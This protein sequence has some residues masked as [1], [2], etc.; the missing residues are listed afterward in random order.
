VIWHCRGRLLDLSQHGVIMGIL[1]VTPDS[2]SDGGKFLSV[3][4]ACEHGLQM[5]SDGAD[6]LDIGGE[7]TRP[8][9]QPV[10]EAEELARVIPV[11]SALREKT[12]LPLSIDTTK[13]AVAEAALEAGA[14]IIN[15]V[16]GLRADKKMAEVVAR[17]QAGLVLMHMQGTPLTMQ[18]A[19]R[20]GNVVRE[21]GDFFRQSIARAIACGVNPMSI[22]LDPGVGF[23]KSPQHNAALLR[24]IGSF[25]QLGHPITVGV[26]RKSFLGWL[27]GSEQVSDRFWP[28]VAL[29]SFCR[30]R[31]GRIFRVHEPKPHCEA[32]RMTEAILGHV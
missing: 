10:T 4:R 17:W 29:T 16:S 5:I 21:L 13:A 18:I 14:D 3:A 23:G 22:S 7:S 27:A 12:I 11:V 19:P 2:F 30:E 31:G 1:N 24:D 15:D 28:G 20:Y 9:S 32:L 6:I 26:S 8:G 25:A